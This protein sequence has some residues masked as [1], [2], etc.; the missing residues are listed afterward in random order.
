MSLY[1]AATSMQPR[2]DGPSQQLMLDEARRAPSTPSRWR[3]VLIKQN[4]RV[5]TP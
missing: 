5:T 4:G 3:F 1:N 2:S